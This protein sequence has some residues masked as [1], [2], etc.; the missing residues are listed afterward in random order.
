MTYVGSVATLCACIAQHHDSVG[1]VPTHH[2]P[3][4]TNHFAHSQQQEVRM[5]LYVCAS[6]AHCERG[7]TYC[8][9]QRACDMQV[10]LA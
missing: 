1:E 9:H 2:K 8:L 3:N 5:R 7:P 10:V 6:K 4:E